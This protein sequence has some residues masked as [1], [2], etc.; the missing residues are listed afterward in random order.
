MLREMLCIGLYDSG[1]PVQC[2][3]GSPACAICSSF[4]EK[5]FIQDGYTI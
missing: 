5:T 2:V 1:V 4:Y 3:P